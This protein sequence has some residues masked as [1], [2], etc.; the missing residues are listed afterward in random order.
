[1]RPQNRD[2]TNNIAEFVVLEKAQPQ[3]GPTS[4][5][6]MYSV[7]SSDELSYSSLEQLIVRQL[8]NITPKSMK[9]NARRSEVDERRSRL[10]T[11]SQRRAIDFKGGERGR[12]RTYN[13]LIK[14]RRV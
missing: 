10:R 12:N 7:D 14:S 4:P 3:F 13:L 6:I 1:M 9:T 2:N 5:E 8:F 11:G